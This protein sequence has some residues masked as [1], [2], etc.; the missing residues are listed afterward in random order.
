M[1]ALEDLLWQSCANLLPS[2]I[3]NPNQFIRWKHPTNGLPDWTVNDNILFLNLN[4]RDDDYGKQRNCKEVVEDGTVIRYAMRTRVWDLNCTAY[5]HQAYNICNT[6][7]D[8][9][10]LPA[11][12][13]ELWKNDVF[14]IPNLPRI[15]QINEVFAGQWWERWD[16]TLNFNEKYIHKEDLG[17]I[18]QIA[19][20]G[21]INR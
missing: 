3:P 4:E 17:H 6:L 15:Q 12:H 16:I 13:N 11:I 19:I 1:Q 8:G 2:I 21:Y 5:G 14:L 20:G 9:F 18:E 10:F 7:K